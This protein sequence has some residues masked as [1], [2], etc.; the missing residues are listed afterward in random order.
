[1]RCPKKIPLLRDPK[2]NNDPKASKKYLGVSK[3]R[4]GPPKSSILIGFSIIFTIHL[5]GKIHYFWKHPPNN[6]PSE[7]VGCAILKKYPGMAGCWTKNRWKFTQNPMDDEN[8]GSKPYEQMDDSGG[9]TTPIFGN[10]FFFLQL[11]WGAPYLP[12]L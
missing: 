2:D 7:P 8:N 9:N 5:G 6:N 4:G 11:S 12:V 10:T 3:N 1:M